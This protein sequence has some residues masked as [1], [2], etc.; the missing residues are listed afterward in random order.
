[1]SERI[2]IAGATGMVGSHLLQALLNERNYSLR[3]TWHQ[4]PPFIQDPAIE[5]LQGDLRQ[6]EFC[7]ALVKDCEIVVMAAAYT[8]GADE[9]SQKPWLQVNNNLLMNIHLLEAI[10][11]SPGIKQVIFI[12]S[13][14]VYQPF[15]GHICESELDLNLMPAPAYLGVGS[16]MRYLEQACQFWQ[17]LCQADFQVIRAANIYGPYAKFD[18]SR[19]NFIPALIRKAVAKMDPFCVWGSPEVTRD[20][21]FAEDFAAGILA[22][23]TKTPTGYEIYNLG[24]ET[25]VTVG[26]AVQHSLEAAQFRPSQVEYIDA[27]KAL[28]GFR[29]LDC[30]KFRQQTDWKPK[31]S[32][33]QG[34]A[35]TVSW[36]QKNQSQWTR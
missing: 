21:I 30:T 32:L 14:T 2:L 28:L 27:H 9:S 15:S 6:P 10:S 18:P 34:I 24:S 16:A 25:K 11:Q 1:M 5:Y 23:L 8:S 13:A 7:Q 20:V 12:S 17:G 31:Y 33:E 35:K 4:T 19:S 22:L 36:W 29:A 3:A 26:D